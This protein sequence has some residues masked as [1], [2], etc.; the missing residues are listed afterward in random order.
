MK[1]NNVVSSKGFTLVELLVVIAIIGILIALLLPAVQAAREAAR[2]MTCTNHLKQLGLAI[3]NY[4]DVFNAVP[5]F[6]FRMAPFTEPLTNNRW[7]NELSGLVALLP[8]IEQN[9]RWDAAK[10]V[11]GT[12]RTVLP[13]NV[14]ADYPIWTE[15][16][17]TYLCPSDGG[18]RSGGSGATARASYRFSVGD[19]PPHFGEANGTTDCAEY[20]S[21]EAGF[22]TSRD[23]GAFG[24]GNYKSLGGIVDGTSNTMAM[25]ERLTG[26]PSGAER[27]MYK[28]GLAIVPTAFDSG[29]RVI[30]DPQLCAGTKGSGNAFNTAATGFTGTVDSSNTAGRYSLSWVS[31]DPASCTF[32]AVLPPNSPSC[33]F[34]NNARNAILVSASSN[35]TGGVNALLMDGSVQFYS[36]S[37][38]SRDSSVPITATKPSGRSPYGTWGALGTRNGGESIQP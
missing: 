33:A 31:G 37:V 15:P 19:Y 18:A 26:S 10:S 7:R 27:T 23:R 28:V 24:I 6:A 5:N 29:V 25:A 36:D 16:V 30:I 17:P 22:S 21:A 1:R 34:D 14:H 38:N 4:H 2:R 8:Y 11:T 13:D 35:H 9:A 32:A 20:T 12:L 3:H